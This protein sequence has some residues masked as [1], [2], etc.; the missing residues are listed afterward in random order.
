[1]ETSIRL[2]IAKTAH[3]APLLVLLACSPNDSKTVGNQAFDA[4]LR[5][6]LTEI[7]AVDTTPF[8][9]ASAGFAATSPGYATWFVG[10]QIRVRG[11]TA[12]W[13][14]DLSVA[15]WGRE[16][17]LQPIAPGTSH[18]DGSRFERDHGGLVEWALN[19]D[20]GLEFGYDI[21]DRPAGDG[22]VVVDLDVSGDLMAAVG[23]SEALF[24]TGDG[25]PR[26]RWTDLRAWGADGSPLVA[27]MSAD[28][29]KQTGAT[30]RISLSVDDSG[31][32]YPLTIDP[33]IASIEATVS[34]FAGP[35]W[36]GYAVDIDGDW[37]IVGIPGVAVNEPNGVAAVLS[38]NTNGEDAWGVDAQLSDSLAS[39]RFGA[40]VAIDFPYAVVGAPGGF[41]AVLVF[42]RTATWQEIDRHTE[43]IPNDFGAAVDVSGDLVVIGA[44]LGDGANNNSGIAYV[45][46]VNNL[47]LVELRGT[48]GPDAAMG[49]S[50]ATNGSWI[51]AGAPNPT[52][53]GA[54]HLFARNEDTGVDSVVEILRIQPAGSHIGERFGS[55]VAF[56]SELIAAGA[57]GDGDGV[58][59]AFDVAGTQLAAIPAPL[60]A[61][62]DFGHDI[63]LEGQTILASD[64]PATLGDDAQI[65]VFE[66]DQDAIGAWGHV[67]SLPVGT[68]NGL[69]RTP[70]AIGNGVVIA[71]APDSGSARIFRRDGERFV[72]GQLT[73]FN[74]YVPGLGSQLGISVAT[75][76]TL[77]ALGAPLYSQA[78]PVEGGIVVVMRPDGAGGWRVDEAI[79][80]P[81]P[82]S[83]QAFGRA[84]ALDGRKLI[85]G[86]PEHDLGGAD[87][88]EAYL[89][90][91]DG[92]SWGLEHRF[93]APA[94]AGA[95][96]GEAVAISGDAV[97]ISAPADGDGSVWV[98]E[99]NRGGRA[100]WGLV[101][102]LQPGPSGR[103]G[104]ALAFELPWLAVGA[105]ADDTSG[106]NAGAVYVYQATANLTAAPNPLT[107]ES[108]LAGNLAG[109]RFGKS[110]A[111]EGD[112]LAAGAPNAPGAGANRGEVLLFRR[113]DTWGLEATVPGLPAPVDNDND[114]FGRSV[115]LW[116]D[117]LFVGAVGA[118]VLA[119]FERNL[120][121]ADAWGYRESLVP[122]SVVSGDSYGVSVAAADGRIVIGAA[123]S[124]QFGLD[125]GWA[126]VI[127][128]DAE[129]APVGLPDFYQVN[130]DGSLTV[131]A[132]GVLA[133]DDDANGDSLTAVLTVL[134]SL[135]IASIDPSTGALDYTPNADVNGFD[136]LQYEVDDGDQRS[137]PVI[138]T[139][140]IVA[141]NDPPVPGADAYA[142]DEDTP[143]VVA[144]PGVLGNDTDID[145][146]VLTAAEVSGPA[147]GVV[148]LQLDGGFTFTP[149][150][151]F[152]GQ[153]AFTY[154]VADNDV[155]VQM[156]VNLTVNSANDPPT[157]IDHI[158]NVQEDTLL[159]V[160]P[161]G[162][163]AGASDADGDPLIAVLVGTPDYGTVLVADNGSIRYTPP[164]QYVGAD[165]FS[166]QVSDGS[167]LSAVHTVTLTI[168]SVND[169][170]VGFP[171]AYQTDEDL[172]L[173][174][175]VANGV[176]ANDFD[177]D[178]GLGALT[179]AV[180]TGPT[181]GVLI[182]QADG[183]FDYTPEPY[184]SGSNSFTYTLHDGVVSS[185]PTWVSIEVFQV[186]KT[187][188]AVDD[189][190]LAP[191]VGP[192][193][194]D[195]LDGVLAND[196]DADG[197]ALTA[198]IVQATR[199]GSL[200]L[201]PAGAFNYSPA[202][203]FS[204]TDTFTY[205]VS[206]A[207]SSATATV[208]I[209]VPGNEDTGIPPT[210]TDPD[211]CALVAFFV[212]A[213]GDGWGDPD[214][215]LEACEPPPGTVLKGKDCDDTLASS[216]PGAKEVASDGV[217]Q[218]CDGVDGVVRAVGTCEHGPGGGGWF[219]AL[220]AL[221]S[222]RRHRGER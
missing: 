167:N 169:A 202:A 176:R 180:A 133:N 2:T 141:V 105:E 28:G 73:D 108:T 61:G 209:A 40:A 140:T 96:F 127:D 88:G 154:E 69:T 38:R 71:G 198:V 219:L 117:K 138:V 110:V 83:F 103:F 114:K 87:S 207:E 98:Y 211:D 102:T 188:V 42:E 89:Y 194:V 118:D 182:M 186:N 187:P 54:V 85:V 41:G 95:N 212:D 86:A 190:Y 113:T 27:E 19:R 204:G 93:A 14:L 189:V 137:N 65:H 1:M 195:V 161:P 111:I 67:Q 185:L 134:P 53:E 170:P 177:V 12:D 37:A 49:T 35:G 17:N 115:A 183:A 129:F 16:G 46:R 81:D 101:Q 216:H 145:G 139:I 31:A 77:V 205:R 112:M 90:D 201:T 220:L 3:L 132:P 156:T 175:P 47:T 135:G 206:D 23:P 210:T 48:A 62:T 168:V 214:S 68:S 44:P 215:R 100:N 78:G 30:C 45:A 13:S 197:D 146:D 222:M 4:S 91:W 5:D 50:I 166:Y 142:T 203:G 9:D 60:G 151:N 208:E 184:F 58:V 157:A 63:A 92:V 178:N 150:P 72:E 163:L 75:G 11:D 171:D 143:L 39:T 144:A 123:T 74:I 174:V 136:T 66:L 160:R 99:L 119:V 80:P 26:L 56:S 124:D 57:P 196:S 125:D 193:Q 64:V 121:G 21:A 20:V 221:V 97:A 191:E 33:L 82:D 104:G 122:A 8:A 159:S 36:A 158:F 217:D 131:V 147:N 94:G 155:Q 6:A 107:L 106:L 76:G 149:D 218:D 51:A 109:D 29:C 25:V 192:L 84:I 162:L 7:R 148:D 179:V 18:A 200:F 32:T 153:D 152:N 172:T 34:G 15:R 120:G 173:S 55:D 164:A 10:E 165:A 126:Y 22:R 59:Y 24:L 52:G 199:N 181:N 116:S 130:E 43:G 213:D 128:L 70:V 79:V